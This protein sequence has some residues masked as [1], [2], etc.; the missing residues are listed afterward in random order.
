MVRTVQVRPGR[1]AVCRLKNPAMVM[2]SQSK[3]SPQ[4]VRLVSAVPWYLVLPFQGM[5]GC[6]SCAECMGNKTSLSVQGWLMEGGGI[7]VFSML[8]GR[9]WEVWI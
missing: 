1:Q 8:C 4:Q 9:K 2:D 7:E 3:I 5:L 6:H